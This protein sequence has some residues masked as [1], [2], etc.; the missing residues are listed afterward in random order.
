MPSALCPLPYARM[1]IHCILRSYYCIRN[2][3]IMGKKQE[4]TVV[5]FKEENRQSGKAWQMEFDNLESLK[6]YL[7]FK[8]IRRFSL[9]TFVEGLGKLMTIKSYITPN[10]LTQDNYMWL[11]ENSASGDKFILVNY[12][13]S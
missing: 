4:K 7:R 12:R 8:T 5:F 2:R 6:N 1:Q 11:K 10:E 3:L 13:R 9:R